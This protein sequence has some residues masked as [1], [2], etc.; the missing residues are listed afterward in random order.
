[1]KKIVKNLWIL[2]IVISLF[3]FMGFAKEIKPGITITKDNY[4]EYLPEL[5]KLL[6]PGTFYD[7]QRPL[8]NGIIT[9]PV[10]ETKEYPQVQPYHEYT[11]KYAGKS[12]VGKN[13]ELIGWEAGLPFPEPK[14]GAEL[15]WNLDRRVVAIDQSSFKGDFFLFDKGKAE[16]KVRWHYWNFY[17]TGRT[18]TTP[19]PEIPGNNGEVRKKESFTMLQ[20]FD[21]RGFSLIRTRYEDVFRPDDVFSYIPA[22]RRL[23]RLTG[24][25]VCDPIAGTD[26]IYDDFELFQQKLTPKM[27]FTMR[28][29]KMLV[30]AHLP[31]KHA[32]HKGEFWQ[33]N[34]EIRP[35]YILEIFSN[36]TEYAYQK[37]IIIME[38]QKKSGTGY[39][40]N[41]Y[42]QSGRLCKGQQ[43]VHRVGPAPYYDAWA[44][45]SRYINYLIDHCSTVDLFPVNP[46]PK[47]KAEN[48]SFRWILKHAR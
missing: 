1:M 23:R 34:W 28:E 15:A 45:N 8:K 4:V 6:D 27:T 5:K 31:N 26:A 11:M 40:V 44:L 29:Q 38:K 10:V 35:V 32:P 20:P 2:L 19:I 3:P 39:A 12:S 33:L 16:R 41:S 17:F 18:A 24:S 30:T 37:R 48:F 36:D 21:I 47:L 25:D 13:N 43:Y 22:I 9:I 14:S 7:I 42:D 46:D